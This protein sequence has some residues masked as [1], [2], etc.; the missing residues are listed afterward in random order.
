M[1]LKWSIQTNR[2]FLWWIKQHLSNNSSWQSWRHTLMRKRNKASNIYNPKTC[3]I[4]ETKVKLFWK[5]LSENLRVAKYTVHVQYQYII[6]CGSEW[7][8]KNNQKFT[9]KINN[10]KVSLLMLLSIFLNRLKLKLFEF[11]PTYPPIH[12]IENKNTKSHSRKYTKSQRIICTI[13]Y[14][15]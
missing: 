6:R 1:Q 5:I 12:T 9:F 10:P 3:R 8:I 13:V 4:T 15:M 7:S 11:L 2:T 14:T